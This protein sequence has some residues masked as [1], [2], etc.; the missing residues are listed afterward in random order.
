MSHVLKTSRV[1]LEAHAEDARSRRH[2]GDQ[3][4]GHEIPGSLYL[5][6]TTAKDVE[7]CRQRPEHSANHCVLALGQRH[8]AVDPLSIVVLVENEAPSTDEILAWAWL[9]KESP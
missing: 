3:V 5:V 7:S 2:L 6:D 9:S 1:A 4:D 8:C